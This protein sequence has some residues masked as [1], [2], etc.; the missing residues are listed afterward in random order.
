MSSNSLLTE[1]FDPSHCL[2]G[3]Y[4]PASD[5]VYHWPGFGFIQHNCISWF[6]HHRHRRDPNSHCQNVPESNVMKGYFQNE[7]FFWAPF[8]EPSQLSGL[9]VLLERWLLRHTTLQNMLLLCQQYSD[10]KWAL[11]T[12]R[13]MVMCSKL[14]KTA[15]VANCSS[16][17][18]S[19]HDDNDEQQMD[20]A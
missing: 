15:H 5:E 8:R 18:I 9:I 17:R 19:V 3:H 11:I 1:L 14:V 16:L 10:V 7:H 2:M 6:H 13:F 20:F 4:Y 12:C